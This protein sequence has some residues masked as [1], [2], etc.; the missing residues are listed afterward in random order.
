MKKKQSIYSVF[1]GFLLSIIFYAG[2]VAASEKAVWAEGDDTAIYGPSEFLIVNGGFIFVEEDEKSG[3][4][5]WKRDGKDGKKTLVK[6]I[7]P[8]G[9]SNPKELVE[10]NGIVFF[11]ADDGVHGYEL[12]KS[13]GTAS[14]TMMVKDINISGHSSPENLQVVDGTLF[15]IANDGIDG[16][17]FWKSNGTEEGTMVADELN[18]T[19]NLSK[20]DSVVWN[21]T[22]SIIMQDS[23]IPPV[24]QIVSGTNQGVYMY[25][26][27][28]SQNLDFGLSGFILN[29]ANGDHHIKSITAMIY[30][31]NDYI[32][33]FWV[34]YGDQDYNDKYYWAILG[35]EILG[36]EWVGTASV[37]KWGGGA[38]IR[39]LGKYT[40]ETKPSQI[41]V[42]LGFH[43]ENKYSDHHVE[44]LAV[45]V[46]WKWDGARNS[47]YWSANLG[48]DDWNDSYTAKI[49]CALV[50]AEN[51]AG[52]GTIGGTSNGSVVRS[53]T[54]TNPMLRGFKFL[55]SNGDHH[56]D[57]VGIWLTRNSAQI[58][59]RDSNAD[60]P[61]RYS[62]SW[63]DC[64]R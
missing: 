19:V 22:Q 62:V 57:K 64:V 51:V 5:L 48:D 31:E 41:P 39:P 26:A 15:F 50:N 33:A 12:W 49:W 38:I 47:L 2:T 1:G 30:P 40:Y 27:S 55:F 56:L 9:H 36:K 58:Y 6:D 43:L 29:F 61:F 16:D 60:D 28:F 53:I 59:F 7:N 35:Q 23:G 54:A 44:V 52:E 11:S 8:T 20:E 4:E 32:N 3:C 24:R 21:E 42:L 13:D 18:G 37:T 25:G 10:L 63:V 34:G 14:G 46:Y 17:R 45:N